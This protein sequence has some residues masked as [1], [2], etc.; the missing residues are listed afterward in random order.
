VI[1]VLL[2]VRD[3][4]AHLAEA[5]GSILRQTVEDL[6]VVVVC[7]G[8]TDRSAGIA[9]AFADP[10]VRVIEQEARGL[11][12]ALRRAREEA[13]GTLLARMDGDDVAHPDRL[14]VQLAL[15]QG[16]GLDACGTAVQLLGQTGEGMHRYRRW[17]NGLLTPE[18]AARDVFVE[19][20]IAHPTLLIR[21][22]ALDRVGGYRDRGWP[23]DHDLL[24]RLWAAGG[25][26]CNT[27]RELLA[28]RQHPQRL[29]LTSE[30]YSEAA[31]V[32]CR[33]H[34]LARTLAR[35]R[36]VVVWGAGPVG[37]AIARALQAEAVTVTAFADVDPRK[38]GNRIDGVPVLSHDHDTP[39]GALVVG[40]VAG[41][42]ARARLRRLAASEGLSEGTDFVAVA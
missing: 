35:G 19:C 6:E 7:D 40:A 15:L 37:K 17:L 3:E 5:L 27:Q 36:E 38:V 31:F 4:E 11:V 21:A 16:D 32:R 30:A 8:C 20:P 41:A 29:S 26:F 23:E 2:P 39:P 22:E 24:L 28:W 33:A 9:R 42:E 18:L 1:S 12:P 25:R 10:R 13:R 14:T 34:H